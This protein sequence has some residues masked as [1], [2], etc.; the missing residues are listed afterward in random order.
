MKKECKNC[1]R[2][3]MCLANASSLLGEY[4]LIC[5]SNDYK[6]FETLDT[7]CESIELTKEL[8]QL[9]RNAKNQDVN[10]ERLLYRKLLNLEVRKDLRIEFDIV[11]RFRL[12]NGVFYAVPFGV[13]TRASRIGNRDIKR[14]FVRKVV[15]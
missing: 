11:C 6:F 3:S 5:I 9:S 4:G 8:N 7:K 15:S 1:K 14:F 13:C 2:K 10:A 12:V